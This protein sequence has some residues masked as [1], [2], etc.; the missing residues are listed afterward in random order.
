MTIISLELTNV[1]NQKDNLFEFHPRLNIIVGTSDN[2]KSA[3]IRGIRWGIRNASDMNLLSWDAKRGESCSVGVE[4]DNGW[5]LRSQSPSK[6]FYVTSI[7][8]NDVLEAFGRGGIPEQVQQITNMSDINI[9][10]Q[11][12]PY[13][14][15]NK[16]P[17]EIARMLNKAVGNEDINIYF[18]RVDMIISNATKRKN[19]IV[20]EAKRELDDAGK[21]MWVD[22]ANKAITELDTQLAEFNEMDAKWRSLSRRINELENDINLQK[23]VQAWL[24]IEKGYLEVK[25]NL[26]KFLFQK[27]KAQKL[28]GLI[29]TCY[30]LNESIEAASSWL[31]LEEPVN[32]IL[33]MI[34][35]IKEKRTQ[36]VRLKNAIA[37]I[38]Q[39]SKSQREAQI[40]CGNLQKKYDQLLSKL[41]VC[42]FCNTKLK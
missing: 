3:T 34:K 13:F 9:R 15:F 30:N 28:Q 41:D 20:V 8:E 6:N 21:L 25:E 14:L 38:E 33:Q 4:F 7:D 26:E 36:S 35:E 18:K 40:R 10:S 5:I 42:P 16:T 19:F 1:Q 11:D 37:S 27:Y 31:E 22:D 24:Q 32:E 23:S 17:G 2:G 39:A 12:D 29:E